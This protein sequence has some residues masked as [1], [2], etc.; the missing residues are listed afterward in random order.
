[1]KKVIKTTQGDAFFTSAQSSGFARWR[2]G[3]L[4][5]PN[6]ETAELALEKN[7]FVGICPAAGDHA[8]EALQN[9]GIV[10][11]SPDG[12]PNHHTP[13]ALWEAIK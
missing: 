3:V 9:A 1:M 6:G 4:T 10:V 12:K 13:S 5:L 11:L 2:F 7:K 8:V